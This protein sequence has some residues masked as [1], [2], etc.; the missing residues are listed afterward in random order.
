MP[1]RPDESGFKLFLLAKTSRIIFRPGCRDIWERAR[2]LPGFHIG[3]STKLQWKFYLK[4]FSLDQEW[5]RKK[6]MKISQVPSLTGFHPDSDNWKKKSN[7]VRPA[8]CIHRY[9]ETLCKRLNANERIW[10]S[11]YLVYNEKC[12]YNSI[13]AHMCKSGLKWQRKRITVNSCYKI[14]TVAWKIHKNMQMRNGSV[15]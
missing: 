5:F 6:K 2:F 3:K 9:I 12:Q 14:T 11:K 13:D 10:K 15:E 1:E 7:R 4:S 8:L